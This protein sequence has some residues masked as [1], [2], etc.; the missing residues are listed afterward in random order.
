MTDAEIVERLK[1]LEQDNRRLKRLGAV[2]IALAAVLIVCF[3]A[4]LSRIW[5]MGGAQNAPEKVMARE[6]DMVDRSGKI[7]A[8]IDTECI[9][10][11]NCWPVISLFDKDG[12][13]RTSIGAGTLNIS[14][15]KGEAE[16]LD[17]VLQFESND[18]QVTPGVTARLDGD[19]D[20]GGRLWLYGKG[21]AY[22][23]VNS[24]PP[25]V[26]L[27]DSQ[28]FMMDLG[29]AETTAMRTGETS[30]TS[31]ASIT[32]FSNDKKGHVIWRA[33]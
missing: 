26:E 31:A 32:M 10:A 6:F 19:A 23:F 9:P 18:K 3:V 21:S 7:R 4:S 22:A 14:G 24:G 30:R 15:D 25:V 33:P 16:L 5:K 8:R 11:D 2:W 20:S 1:K 12:K 28:G 27:Q 29:T 13:V 17:S